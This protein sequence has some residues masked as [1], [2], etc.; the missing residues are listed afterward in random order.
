MPLHKDGLAW[1]DKN[2]TLVAAQFR[3]G[4]RP[5]ILFPT[6]GVIFAAFCVWLGVRIF[7]RRERWAKWMLL[8][9]VGLPL[10]YVASFGPA[11]WLASH[12]RIGRETVATVYLSA[13]YSVL[14]PRPETDFESLGMVDKPYSRERMALGYWFRW[15]FRLDKCRRRLAA[16]L[17]HVANSDSFFGEANRL[18]CACNLEIQRTGRMHRRSQSRAGGGF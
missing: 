17:G 5:P 12:M 9:A 18:P 15:L 7:N 14:G 4:Q 11:C 13:T 10:L 2:P 8:G 3:V 6:L 1:F 16:G